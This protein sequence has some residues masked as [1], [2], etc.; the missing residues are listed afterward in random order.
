MTTPGQP[1]PTVM[2]GPIHKADIIFGT[3]MLLAMLRFI[4]CLCY[5]KIRSEGCSEDD[6]GEPKSTEPPYYS[7]T[8]KLNSNCAICLEDFKEG[9]RCQVLPSCKHMFHDRCVNAW[10]NKK[11]R[12]P[13][14]RSLHSPRY[15]RKEIISFE[16]GM[17]IA[18]VV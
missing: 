9:D 3:S 14:C 5:A 16:R 8:A 4:F 6:S 15:F 18:D 13:T 7:T 11:K 1:L 12:C 10:L 2:V 17:T